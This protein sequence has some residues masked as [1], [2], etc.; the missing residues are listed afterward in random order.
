[1]LLGLA[2]ASLIFGTALAS[3]WALAKKEILWCFVHANTFVLVVS[4]ESNPDE[5]GQSGGVVDV[6]HEVPGKRLDKSSPNK[7]EWKFVDGEE[8][9]GLLHFILGVHWIGPFRSLRNNGVKDS[10]EVRKYVYYSREQDVVVEGVK[11]TGAYN[12]NFPFN[13]L[14]LVVFPVRA[15]LG[16]ANPNSV[17]N[18]MVGEVVANIAGAHEPEYFI[19]GDASHKKEVVQAIKSIDSDILDKIGISLHSINLLP[20]T[21]DAVSQKLFELAETT[22][23]ENVAK[24]QIAETDKQVGILANDVKEDH[25]NRVLIPTGKAEGGPAVRIAEAIEKTNLGT[26]ALGGPAPVLPVISSDK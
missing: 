10:K 21:L 22:R 2:V 1:L 23:R 7:L 13:T 18:S 9:H 25:V 26:L 3:I 11:T 16:V 14:Y 6:L 8:E 19:Q 17:L 15:I 5:V 12:L 4:G 24:L 20:I